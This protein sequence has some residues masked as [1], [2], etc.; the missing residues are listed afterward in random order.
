SQP[1]KSQKMGRPVACASILLIDLRS[2]ATEIVSA[3]FG[4]GHWIWAEEYDGL[5][6]RDV[7]MFDLEQFIA[8]SP[9]VSFQ[10]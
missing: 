8:V 10:C 9:I 6:R 5:S 7:T 4:V 3:A 1:K 2:R